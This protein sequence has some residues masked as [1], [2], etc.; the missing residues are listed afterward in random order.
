[1]KVAVLDPVKL[2]ENFL[3]QQLAIALRKFKLA[4][5]ALLGFNITVNSKMRELDAL[6][7][8]ESGAIIC[9]ESKGYRGK[10][11]GSVNSKWYCDESE[12]NSSKGLNPYTQVQDYAV[13]V[14][15][16]LSEIDFHDIYVNSLIVCSDGSD[17]SGIES[18][19]INQ[20]GNGKSISICSLSNLESVLSSCWKNPEFA[21]ELEK[22]GIE[23]F[24]GQLVNITPVQL[25]EFSKVKPI[26]PPRKVTAPKENLPDSKIISK[27]SRSELT[28]PIAIGL[29][30]LMIGGF[31]A[32]KFWQ[33]NSKPRIKTDSLTIGILAEPEK[34]KSLQI[35]LEKELLIDHFWRYLQG[36]RLKISIDGDVT[37]Q[38]QE[39]EKRISQKKWDIAFS[40]SPMISISAQENK[41]LY[42]ARMFPNDPTSYRST[43]FV[44][45]DSK[46]NSVADLKPQNTI[47]LRSNNSASGFFMPLYDLYGK[48]LTVKPNKSDVEILALVES[49][50][51]DVGTGVYSQLTENRKIRLLGKP[52]RDIPGSGVYLSPKFSVQER[53]MIRKAMFSAS[54]DLQNKANYGNGI[55]P[56]YSAFKKIVKRVKDVLQ[57]R[58]F[59]STTLEPTKIFCNNK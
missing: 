54:K 45:S 8:L 55:E 21:K 1:M 6:I 43:L 12:I 29:I 32:F 51:V 20:F 34:Y 31:L 15:N 59:S 11:S 16:K 14:K 25:Q 42:L 13:L 19:N 18:A 23:K 46:I 53:D 50:K 9:L 48:T 2:S 40:R 36:D 41:Y 47:A 3:E 7:I 37:L 39:A 10:W 27:S 24:A 28:L 49:G 38:Y 33:F 22:I 17:F 35:Y 57:C 44:R 4:G 26:Q 5:Y 30:P 58:D 52:S 56:G